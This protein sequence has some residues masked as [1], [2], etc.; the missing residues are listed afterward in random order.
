MAKQTNEQILEQL[1][2]EGGERAQSQAAKAM[3]ELKDELSRTMK[4]SVATTSAVGKISKEGA[5]AQKESVQVSKVA[6]QTLKDVRQSQKELISLAKK[7][8]GLLNNLVNS[9]N[10]YYE[11]NNELLRNLLARDTLNAKT[12][13]L[14]DPNAGMQA[15][16]G[17]PALGVQPSTPDATGGLGGLAIDLASAEAIRKLFG[18]DKA[19]TKGVETREGGTKTSDKV[20]GEDRITKPKSAD[21]ISVES[22]KVAREGGRKKIEPKVTTEAEVKPVEDDFRAKKETK[23]TYEEM[24]EKSKNQRKLGL[25]RKEPTFDVT[26][27]EKPESLASEP[28]IKWDEKTGRFKR[29]SKFISFAEAEKYG[30]KK[31]GVITPIEASKASV[32][33]ESGVAIQPDEFRAPKVSP[34]TVV[35]P[36]VGTG[37]RGG[38]ALGAALGVIMDLATNPELDEV[39]KAKAKVQ[40]MLAS[41]KITPEQAQ[42]AFKELDAK[43]AGARGESLYS[44]VKEG[45]AGGFGTVAGTLTT[46]V[47]GPVGGAAIGIGGAAVLSEGI[48]DIAT[49]SGAK[50]LIKKGGNVVGR[51]IGEGVDIARDSASSLTGG[52]ISSAEEAR[53]QDLL[54]AK[55][56]DEE[57][58]ARSQAETESVTAADRLEKSRQEFRKK[59][60]FA[61]FAGANPDMNLDEQK[62]AYNEK[63]KSATAGDIEAVKKADENLKKINEETEK[64]RSEREK[65]IKSAFEAKQKLSE[66]NINAIDSSGA[67][68]GG[69]VNIVKQGDTVNNVVNNNGAAGGSIATGHFNS[70]ARVSPWDERLYGRRGLDY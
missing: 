42:A 58:K 13:S 27:A 5:D 17:G 30:F 41:G 14:R 21:E 6:S 63:I 36:K 2:K 33:G 3:K 54:K 34:K 7:T 52:Y 48:E 57:Q 60:T 11:S 35:E 66:Q 67:G 22:E 37:F 46:P 43:A 45:I 40:Q 51:A 53:K 20:S 24:V 55:F 9:S 8:N 23:P 70:T 50:Q 39:N 29:G 61:S 1:I 38:A 68:G 69:N 4:D 65:N 16:R 25:E 12:A 28:D 47:V 32:A 49:R 56:T 10:K 19:G 15:G 62:K 59:N 31:P 44:G 64:A 18:R 26:P